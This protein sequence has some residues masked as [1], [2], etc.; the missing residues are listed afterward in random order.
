[1]NQPFKKV[2]ERATKIVAGVLSGILAITGGVFA[3]KL[4]KKD[5]VNNELPSSI[6]LTTDEEES[7]LDLSNDFDINNAEE[8]RKRAE[9]IYKISEKD[10]SVEDIINLI[11]LANGEYNNINIDENLTD[12]E[13]F[14]Y[15][16]DL[17]ISLTNLLNDNIKDD[18]NSLAA[19]KNGE[20]ISVDN[21]M[22]IYSYMLFASSNNGKKLAIKL[23]ELINEQLN[24]ISHNKV[25]AYED[26]AKRFYELYQEIKKSNESDNIMFV[27]TTDAKAKAP[28]VALNDKQAEDIYENNAIYTNNVGFKIVDVLGINTNAVIDANGEECFGKKVTPNGN[29]YNASDAKEA[30]QMAGN[31]ST[32]KVMVEEGGKDLGSTSQEISGGEVIGTE[33]HSEVVVI[34]NG[35][36]TVEVEEG[37]KVVETY[38]ET[39][40]PDETEIVN[41]PV[42]DAGGETVVFSDA[43]EP[44]ATYTLR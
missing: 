30:E 27:L 34:D 7:E 23:A 21:D 35:G 39:N 16:Q 29:S 3:F 20:K 36:E 24:N 11:Y 2:K 17:I 5:Q 40:I 10:V 18:V 26:V 38:V 44:V 31:S 28:L 41:G 19:S 25:D 33:K 9:A 37:G 1:M 8:V 14:E 42:V 22:E 15:V 12:V 6:E 4:S 43:D 32:D 13:K